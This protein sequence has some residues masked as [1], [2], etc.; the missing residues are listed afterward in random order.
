MFPELYFNTQL[1]VREGVNRSCLQEL[2]LI[3]SI[4]VGALRFFLFVF[5]LFFFFSV[6]FLSIL[7]VFVYVMFS[8]YCLWYGYYAFH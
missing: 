4:H 2:V 5:F 6:N 7:I 8:V 1:N 3:I